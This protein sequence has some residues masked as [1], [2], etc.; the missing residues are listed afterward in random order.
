[1]SILAPLNDMGVSVQLSESGKLK[2]KG[3]P[4]M[5]KSQIDA[6]IEYA[7]THKPAIIEA[8]SQT[9]KPGECESCPAAGYWDGH[10]SG[11][12]CF[13]TAYYLHKSGSPTPC[14]EA[15]LN[16]PRGHHG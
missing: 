16:C 6:A 3:S 4:D 12:L 7:R 10:Y 13:H 15:R 9:G 2:I 8:L 1:M 11:L 14:R 5:V